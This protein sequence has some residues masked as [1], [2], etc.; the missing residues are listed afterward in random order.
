MVARVRPSRSRRVGRRPVGRV[1]RR[2]VS[3]LDYALLLGVV[4]PM[5]AFILRIAP[6]M[7]GSAYEMVNVLISWPFM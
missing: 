3:A 5:V 4:L 6:R 2:G 7:I 1:A